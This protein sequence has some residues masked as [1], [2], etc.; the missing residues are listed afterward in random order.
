M[1]E[2]PV[3]LE[4]ILPLNLKLSEKKFR[5][6]CGHE[7]HKKCIKECLEFKPEGG[8]P[9]RTCPLCGRYVFDKFG[10]KMLG[11][12]AQKDGVH[13]YDQIFH[14]YKDRFNSDALNALFLRALEDKNEKLVGFLMSK[15][16]LMSVVVELILKKRRD[17]LKL[18]MDSGR[19]NMH[20]TYLGSTILEHAIESKNQDII[21]LVLDYCSDALVEMVG[22]D[23]TRCG[24]GGIV[25][26]EERNPPPPWYPT[27]TQKEERN[28]PPP[29]PWYPTSTQKEIYPQLPSAPPYPEFASNHEVE[30]RMIP[31]S[32]LI[33]ILNTLKRT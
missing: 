20:S 19:V 21:N 14:M 25:R 10:K 33:G 8:A 31:L 16:D 7:F 3:C 24:G 9:R 5:L 22:K 17:E 4:N 30:D 11:F 6:D 13:S 32:S 29:P 26:I 18:V 12:E 27:S 2:C 23:K 1:K 15:V 28:P